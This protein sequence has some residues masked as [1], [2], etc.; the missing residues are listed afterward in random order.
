MTIFYA[1]ASYIEFMSSRQDLI[2]IFMAQ[3][4]RAPLCTVYT[5]HIV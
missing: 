2:L 3:Q 4:K 1:R 5:V